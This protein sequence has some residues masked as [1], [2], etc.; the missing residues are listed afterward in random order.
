MRLIAKKSN[1]KITRVRKRHL[2]LIMKIE[3][4]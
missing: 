4:D 2:K 1:K 3:E